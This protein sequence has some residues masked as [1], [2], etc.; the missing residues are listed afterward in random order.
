[1]TD[2]AEV[3]SL[4]APL[5]LYLQ[6]AAVSVTEERL[7]ALTERLAEVGVTRICNLG[8]TQ[9][10]TPGWRPDGRPRLAELVR[11]VDWE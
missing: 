3:P 6:T 5:A 10:P 8:R 7:R 1:M 9:H 4:V 11:W 2:L